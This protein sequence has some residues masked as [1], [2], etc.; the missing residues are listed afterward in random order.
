MMPMA[1]PSDI[2]D[3]MSEDQLLEWVVDVADLFGWRTYHTHDSRHSQR[4][5]PD[6]VMVRGRRV[7]FAELK[8]ANGTLTPEQKGWLEAL[9][10]VSSGDAITGSNPKGVAEVEV[11][12]WRPSDQAEVERVLR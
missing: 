12:L 10:Y 11:Y 6:L 8:S 2:R 4:G 3:A 1:R 7:I 9:L 5:F